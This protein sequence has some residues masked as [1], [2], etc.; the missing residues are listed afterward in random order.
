MKLPNGDR[1][2]I[3]IRK[4][5]DYCLNVNHPKGKD[6]ARVFQAKLGITMENA[7]QLL[8]LIQVAAVEGEVVQQSTTAF[9]Q[10]Y[11]VDWII[12]NSEGVELRT[13][14]EIAIGTDYPRLIT[15]FVRR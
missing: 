15:A 8:Q 13:T 1:A 12:P 14:W 4:L 10:Q 6:K 5:I 2:D 3:P 9:G 11:K 7:E